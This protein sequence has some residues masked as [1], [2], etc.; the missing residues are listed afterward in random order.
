MKK[1]IETGEFVVGSGPIDGRLRTSKYCDLGD[2]AKKLKIG[3]WM[4][5]PLEK[6]EDPRKKANLISL[7]IS[8]RFGR[9]KFSTAI[10]TDR[11]SIYIIRRAM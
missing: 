10:H 1:K 3:E 2:A 7:S 11:T 4:L 8:Y 6:G 5:V 9:G